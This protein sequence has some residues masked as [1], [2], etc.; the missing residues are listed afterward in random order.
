LLF[1]RHP[2]RTLARTLALV[3][4]TFILFRYVLALVRIEGPSMLPTCRPNQV[5]VLNRLA[6]CFHEP[7]RGDIVAIRLRAR[8]GALLKRIV[9]LPGETIA[10]RHGHLEVNGKLINEPYVKFPCNWEM[11]RRVL[12]PS[13]YYVVGDNRSMAWWDHDQGVPERQRIM[14][15]LLL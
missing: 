2:R 12:G 4:G 13:E 7:R 5:R 14:G 11:S 3:V 8:R 10:F 9:G 1:G 6:Y 15:K